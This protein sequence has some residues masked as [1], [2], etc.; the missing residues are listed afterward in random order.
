MGE[1]L[2][3][4]YLQTK[5]K[6]KANDVNIIEKKLLKNI[7]KMTDEELQRW[8]EDVHGDG[9]D[10][11]NMMADVTKHI[12]MLSEALKDTIKGRGPRDLTLIDHKGETLWIAG[13][14]SWGDSPGE[15]FNLFC[16]ILSLP[17][18]IIKNTGIK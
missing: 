2:I 10:N 4:Q 3:L 13:G 8:S 11:K 12:R 1:D 14:S 6:L 17:R 16:A 18:R 5:Q 9:D 15:A 7:K